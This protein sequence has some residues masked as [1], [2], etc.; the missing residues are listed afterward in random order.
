MEYYAAIAALGYQTAAF[1]QTLAGD[2]SVFLIDYIV[3][4]TPLVNV[5][6]ARYVT[7]CGRF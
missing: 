6:P 3:M 4:V 7:S 2:G 5:V 1:S